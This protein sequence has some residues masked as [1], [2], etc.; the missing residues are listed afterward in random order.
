MALESLHKKDLVKNEALKSN[1]S[2][3]SDYPCR[4]DTLKSL[5]GSVSSD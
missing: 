1:N 2:V 4:V 5:P 3:A